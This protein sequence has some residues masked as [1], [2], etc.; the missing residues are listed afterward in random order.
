MWG[1]IA[2]G[3]TVSMSYQQQ[4]IRGYELHETIG[5]GG[6]G[7]IY[8][9]YQPLLKRE[10]AIKV[11]L[12]RYANNPE[13]IRRFEVEAELVARLE[14]PNIVPLFD[15]WREPDGA[16]L[17]MRLLRGGS[18]RD[19]LAKG[20]VSPE[21]TALIVEQIANALHIA[22]RNQVVHRD[23]KPG[24]IL[25]DEDGN[26]Y[27]TDF[28]IA[29][30][31]QYDSTSATDAITGSL[32][33]AA[34]EQIQSQ[35]L[36]AQTDIYA[37]GFV[38]Y[39]MLTGQHP[40]ADS[41]ATS[42]LFK[43][44]QE[45][46]PDIQEML[47]DLPVAVDEVLQKATA[48]HDAERFNDVREMAQA[49]R[50]ALNGTTTA[51]RDDGAFIELAN[52][53]Q[54][55]RAF[56]EAD[57][58]RFFGRT[59]LVERLLQQLDADV[60]EARFLAVVG[61]SGSGKSSV[62]KAGLIPALRQGQLPDS[63]KWFITEMFPGTHPFEELEAALLRVAV[64]PPESLLKQL[65]E[66]ERGIA[67]TVKRIL[68][69]DDSEL[70]L[71]IDQFEELFTLVD[72][73]AVRA[74]FLNSLLAVIADSR[75][76]VRVVI[77]FR[78]DFYDRPLQ[79]R[80]FGELLRQRTEII[81]PMSEAELQQAIT[82]PLVTV[83]AQ[84]QAGLLETLL[85][86]VR[87]QPGLLPLLQYAL[88]ELFER[89]SG[90]T[91]TLEAYQAIGGVTGALARRAEEC[92]LQLDAAGQA[93]ARQL[94]LRLVT[95]GEGTEDTRRRVRRSELAQHPQLDT[96]LERYGQYRLLTFD[97]DP[98][99]REP[100]IELTHE[101]LLRT[102]ERLREWVNQRRDELRLHRRLTLATNEW[103]EGAEDTGLLAQETR[104]EQFDAWAKQTDMLLNANEKRYLQA[105]L[106]ARSER[107]QGEVERKARE[108]LIARRVQNFQRASV[109]LVIVAAIAAMATVLASF[110]FVSASNQAGTA[111]V[112]RGQALEQAQQA[113]LA[114][115]A[116]EQQAATAVAE[117]NQ[118][119]AQQNA[120]ETQQL[121]ALAQAT[122]AASAQQQAEH[123][124]ETAVAEQNQAR[125]DAA[126][127]Q[128][129]QN[130]AEAQAA[131]AT[132]AQGAA[133]NLSIQAQ[134]SA[135]ELARDVAL[136][137]L[138]QNRVA[139][140]A[141]GAVVI[142]YRAAPANPTEFIAS[143][144]EIA[145]LNA[146]QPVEM[147]DDYGVVL[148]EVPAGCFYMGSVSGN[149]DEQ[150]I[151]QQCVDEPF[152]ID[153]FEVTNAQY[154]RVTNETPPSAIT[155]QFN[156][157][158]SITW[159]AARDFCALRGARLP[160]ELEWEYAARGPDSVTY[161]WG[162]YYVREFMVTFRI[163]AD[164]TL[165]VMDAGGR[166]VRPGS[167][168]W[169]GAV[170]MAGNVYEWTSTIYDYLDYS[171]QTFVFM[172]F[173]P[174]P[175]EADERE[176]DESAEE[177]QARVDEDAIY[178]MRVLRGG[179]FS[180]E[181]NDG[182]SANRGRLFPSSDDPF[183]GFRCARDADE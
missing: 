50:A 134:A 147:L 28:G 79:Y 40:W 47:P 162:N 133:E 31:A 143:L 71:V 103:L 120:A 181:A 43:H 144:T 182:R 61:P 6:F 159:F 30:S 168:S 149:A 183:I 19:A 4:T 161:P 96:M 32:P 142:P 76:H 26:A 154:Q 180:L 85:D 95:L 171:R 141:A 145:V 2:W 52:P 179:S 82:Q 152:W 122:A 123:Q 27:L 87:E 1:K 97:R 90:R 49:F 81:L 84:L 150:P 157:V 74:L 48:K 91:L 21:R 106:A 41:A 65:R 51:S 98:L 101:A 99:T 83:Q 119:Q 23:I 146:W 172:D 14:H 177:Y 131:S 33:Y 113:T 89:R 7:A 15:Y 92:F 45:P 54:G 173:F 107:E 62:V 116:A 108:A 167:A 10:V 34:P 132:H 73:E 88:T 155:G 63:E 138:Q 129:Q 174:Y 5:E 110:A 165:P 58:D 115:G 178:T 124:A 112:E 137:G 125:D 164:G 12:P 105:S 153:K 46:L 175:Y 17:V 35:K 80:E 128:A 127:A 78:A 111:T 139:T 24:N 104:L 121:I 11:I 38:V 20:S 170:D 36:S 169:V 42:L 59:A 37:L 69:T 3:K 72:D 39:E 68:P 140:L 70:L 163:T 136:F 86:D 100:T 25:L 176:V 8:R 156:P 77:T 126:T 114:Q 166:A 18:L 158:D 135:T 16:Y 44:L 29:K 66:D 64:N 148:V 109:V 160:T 118:A 53:Y 94:F 13:F 75:S 102:W 57:A 151:Q 60:V 130:M 55:L 67:R 22:H 9:A 56:Q 117:Q 93:A